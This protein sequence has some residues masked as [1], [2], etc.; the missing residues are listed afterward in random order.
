[1][2]AKVLYTMLQCSIKRYIFQN[3]SYHCISAIKCYATLLDLC[4][5]YTLFI[6]NP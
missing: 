5:R 1:M 3:F 2:H 4:S 6:L